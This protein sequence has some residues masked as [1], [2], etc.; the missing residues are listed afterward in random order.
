VTADDALRVAKS[1]IQPDHF[2][3]VVVGD[4]NAIQD[5]LATV[6]PVTLVDAK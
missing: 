6:A 1:Y 5:A 4:A 2:I 3:I